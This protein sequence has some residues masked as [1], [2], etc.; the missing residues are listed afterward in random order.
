MQHLMFV[1]WFLL[2][3]SITGKEKN[4]IKINVIRLSLEIE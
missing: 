3:N 2:M 1:H 4:K